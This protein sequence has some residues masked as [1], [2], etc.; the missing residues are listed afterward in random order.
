MGS[1]TA[2]GFFRNQSLTRN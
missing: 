1:D 2:K